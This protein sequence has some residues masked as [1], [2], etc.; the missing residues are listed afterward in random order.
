MK[1]RIISLIA[2]V[3]LGL[4]T[5]F[6]QVPTT[7]LTYQ[8]VVRNAQNQLV[9]NQENVTVTVSVWNGAGTSELYRE[10]HSGLSTNA[11]G[12][13]TLM[14]GTGTVN[15]GTWADI[16]WSDAAIKTTVSYGS[17][18]I[19][20]DLM[21]VTAVP[22]AMQAGN[23]PAN[24]SAFTND[25]GYI[26]ITDVPGQ[27]NADWNATSGV[28]QILNKPDLSVYATNAAL[29]DFQTAT[30]NTL[31]GINNNLSNLQ[32]QITSNDNDI[33]ALQNSDA[34]INNR[35]AT[36]SAALHNALIDSAAAIRG[37]LNTMVNTTVTNLQANI[38][39]A[40][41]QIRADMGTMNTHLQANIDTASSQ[42]R[43]DMGTMNSHLQA[44][45]DTASQH[46]RTALVDTAAAI[47]G[48]LNTMVNT[49]IT[50]L[51]ANI[52]TASSQI[53][54]DMGTMSTNLQA[55]I[56]TAS[57]HVRAALVDT[58]VAIRGDIHNA[59]LTIKQGSTTLGTFTA[60]ASEAATITVP[61][62][63][64]Q[65][66]ADWTETTT[67]SAAYIQNKPDLS[68]FATLAGDNT[69]SGA[70]AFSSTVTVPQA[71][72]QTTFAYTNDEM[73]AVAYKDLKF[74]FDSIQRT[75]AAMQNEISDLRHDLDSIGN[76]IA[77][78]QTAPS[79]TN[80]GT[81]PYTYSIEVASSVSI[82]GTPLTSRMYCIN[83]TNDL[84]TATCVEDNADSHTFSDLSANTQY[85]IWIKATNDVGTTVSDVQEVKTLYAKPTTGTIFAQSLSGRR[86][87]VYGTN[88]D[89][90]GAP[91][92]ELTL[93]IYLR[94]SLT[95][96]HSE[97][98]TV[99][100]TSFSDTIQVPIQGTSFAVTATIDNGSSEGTGVSNTINVTVQLAAPTLGAMSIEGITTSSMTVSIP[101]SDGGSELTTKRVCAAIH[102]TTDSVCKDMT[103][104]EGILSATLD[105]LSNGEDYDIVVN[106]ATASGTASVDSSATTPTGIVLSVTPSTD[107]TLYFCPDEETKTV[108]YTASITG[109]DAH[110]SQYTYKWS[111]K[112]GISGASFVDSTEVTTN[113]LNVNIPYPSY[114][115][116][117]Y[118]VQ[119][120]AYRADN[121]HFKDTIVTT[122]RSE[123]ASSYYM[124]LYSDNTN[125]KVKIMSVERIASAS[126]LNES[127]EEKY[128][129]K[130]TGTYT[131]ENGT[132]HVLLTSTQG[133]QKTI[134][135]LV[136]TNTPPKT[137][138]SGLTANSNETS[139]SDGIVSVSDD[140]GLHGGTTHTYGV[141]KLNG[142]CVMKE[143]LRAV[144][145][146]S[147]GNLM[148]YSP[149]ATV[150]T[151][152][153][154]CYQYP[155]AVVYNW[156]AAVDTFYAA[157]GK[158]EIG[159]SFV[160]D[161]WA[162]T[163]PSGHRRGACP[164][165]WH[166]PTQS[167][168]A[169]IFSGYTNI[170]LS[171]GDAWTNFYGSANGAGNYEN[172]ERNSSGFSA[173]P[174]KNQNGYAYYSSTT[175]PSSSSTNTSAYYINYF[176]DAP[177]VYPSWNR[178]N[179]VAVRCVRDY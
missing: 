61:T 54:T 81:T 72:N 158:P 27:V 116:L 111:V 55:N 117:S 165:G 142:Y 161:S 101:V 107:E 75:F 24:V 29:N 124:G 168:W 141:V 7:P 16:D 178:G 83:T 90:K 10:T 95:Q 31:T 4:M 153:K 21:P 103:L 50:N 123:R 57:Q 38:D 41:S 47:R 39:T 85:Y 140:D 68:V 66:Q 86:V 163:I 34:T 139:D 67:T 164:Q 166:I 149:M 108:T 109:D 13:L 138:C 100:G 42:I 5:A 144:Y 143:D 148:T 12:L 122:C 33:L 169:A 97:T 76:L 112:T 3:V 145:S 15:L 52:D 46:V 78:S 136:V 176:K 151:V 37:D 87:R 167:E 134:Q 11:N 102:G 96:S 71:M 44:N 105:G 170:Q 131:L 118:S 60:N 35:I 172:Q 115:S 157:G 155:S 133:C 120:I 137:F 58:A 79:F 127:D 121:L 80:I 91:E 173:V 63:A 104:N 14:M 1:K 48:D 92:G 51:Q 125:S 17:V 40:S 45:I 43:T 119:C 6:A 84:S 32:S 98:F 147:T 132:Y 89:L 62:P 56:D 162:V 53:R 74:V 130:T 18:T 113:V 64:A 175:T 99:S 8:T 30:N 94:P 154:M 28:S 179:K 82:G 23:V 59:T 174:N 20:S 146:P 156:C 77:A 106:V 26:T 159:T 22:Y 2:L 110:L 114:S 129:Y 69:F 25:A 128:T 19:P 49:T 88:M 70:N 36:D 93:T 177:E 160:N 9:I 171:S 152:S 126:W 135:D 65:V 150:N 73:Q